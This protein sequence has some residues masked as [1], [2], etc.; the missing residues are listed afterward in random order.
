M[1]LIIK[2]ADIKIYLAETRRELAYIRIKLANKKMRNIGYGAPTFII[3][4][5][6][7]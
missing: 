1:N 4:T 3:I 7:L 2:M 5:L 6:P